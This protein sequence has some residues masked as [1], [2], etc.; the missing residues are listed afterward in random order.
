MSLGIDPIISNFFF[1]LSLIPHFRKPQKG[2]ICCITYKSLPYISVLV[3]L[4]HET[5]EDINITISSLIK[6]TYPKQYY[7]VL[8]LIEPDDQM[9]KI[10]AK[11]CLK[12]LCNAGISGRIIKSDGKLKMK[13]HALNFGI[14]ESRGT[15]CAFYDASDYIEKDQIER[16]ISLM[17]NEKYDVVQAIVLRKGR[18][19][20]SCFLF[21]DT[22]LWFRKYLP[23]MLRYANGMPLSGEGLFI[24]KCV[25]EEVG[26]FPEVLTEDAEMG[27]ILTEKNKSFA[28]LESI[29]VEKTPK[30]IKAHFTQKLRWFRGYLSC[31]SKLPQSNLTL[32]K[33]FF[34]L[35]L[36]VSPINSALAF[37][38]WLMI[39]IFGISEIFQSNLEIPIFWIKCSVY[40][41]ILYY[42]SISLVCFGIPLCILSY[43]HTLFSSKMGRYIPLLFLAPVYWMFVGFCAISSFFRGKKHWGKTNR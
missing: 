27:L 26:L 25:L 7:E 42:W 36:F 3:A 43:G 10:Y 13:P 23:F 11:E 6:Q 29:V 28:L 4:Y 19:F 38:G 35:L 9:T 8:M 16:A 31:L 1:S 33:K 5:Q 22:L 30:N 21:F 32:K 2:N 40:E 18:S 17:I 37:L 15:Y 41:N 34:F 24:K 39:I 20:L 14:K 12:K